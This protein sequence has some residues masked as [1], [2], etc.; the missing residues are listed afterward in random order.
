M[1]DETCAVVNRNPNV[2]VGTCLPVHRPDLPT[3]LRKLDPDRILFGSDVPDL[4]IPVG[5][6]PILYARISDDLK[7]KIMGLNAQRLLGAVAPNVR[8][9]SV[10]ASPS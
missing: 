3:A 7:R 10:G 1:D 2:Y 5:F 9:R 8:P 6:G 4:P